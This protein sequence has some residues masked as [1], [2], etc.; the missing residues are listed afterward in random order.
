MGLRS[1]LL[2]LVS[3][4]RAIVSAIPLNIPLIGI[5]VL[6]LAGF[7]SRWNFV[8]DLVT[9]F[10]V[11]YL[12]VSGLLFALFLGRHPRWGWKLSLFCLVLNLSQVVPWYFPVPVAHAATDGSALRVMISNVQAKNRNYQALTELIR[13]EQ[14]DLLILLETNPAWLQTMDSVAS[15]LPYGL[16]QRNTHPTDVAIYSRF[17]LTEVSLGTASGAS[18]TLKSV[19][20]DVLVA[21]FERNG[22]LGVAIAIHPPPPLYWNL[23]A[24][25]NQV[26]QQVSQYIQ[27]IQQE[28]APGADHIILGGDFNI[29]MWSA[30]YRELIAHT[31]LKNSRDGFGILPTWPAFAPPLFIPI[32]HCL[33]S[34]NISVVDVHTGPR[35]GSDHLPIVTDLAYP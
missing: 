23:F 24:R 29:T 22:V 34:P 6:S 15:L 25:R 17:P 7:L 4:V 10:R 9:H 33:T 5:L 27:H 18:K 12:L 30:F 35:I 11:Q 3:K 28:K 1:P 31:G 26:L 32:D 16:N 20:E 2:R 13:K 19:Q 8:F 14:P 21:Q